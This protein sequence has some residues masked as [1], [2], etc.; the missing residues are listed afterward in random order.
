MPAKT[1]SRFKQRLG[2]VEDHLRQ[3]LRHRRPG[4]NAFSVSRARSNSSCGMCRPLRRIGRGDV[5]IGAVEVA[6][7]GGIEIDGRGRQAEA[8]RVHFGG[9][10]GGLLADRPC[11]AG[12]PRPA[13]PAS[14]AAPAPRRPCRARPRPRSRRGR[15][16]AAG[17]PGRCPCPHNGPATAL[18]RFRPG[19]AK[20]RGRKWTVPLVDPPAITWP[21]C[22]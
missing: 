20:R 10:A 12:R 21:S 18:C 9:E 7:L 8:Q 13:R 3:R 14:P 1:A 16:P 6:A 2:A 11:A 17:R 19:D 22:P 4:S 5:A 15:S